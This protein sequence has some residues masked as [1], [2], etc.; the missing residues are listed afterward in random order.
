MQII[1][2]CLET[3]QMQCKSVIFSLFNT[4]QLETQTL[5]QC[6]LCQNQIWNSCFS[7]FFLFFFFFLMP[8]RSLDWKSGKQY[9]WKLGKWKL[10]E[11]FEQNQRNSSGDTS[12]L[13]FMPLR[14]RSLFLCHTLI[15]EIPLKISKLFPKIGKEDSERKTVSSWSLRVQTNQL[16]SHSV[17]EVTLKWSIIQHSLPLLLYPR[18]LL[19]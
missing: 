11:K 6:Y 5:W 19:V 17:R 14:K 18:K 15:C 12:L 8:L 3:E 13:P 4:V 16:K 1:L 2:E 9:L 7:L 10:L